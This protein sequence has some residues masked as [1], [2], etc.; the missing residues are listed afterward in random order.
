MG[1][2]NRRGIECVYKAKM[3]PQKVLIAVISLVIISSP[4]IIGI[5]SDCRMRK[6][7]LNDLI[8]KVSNHPRLTKAVI[9]VESSGNRYAKSPKGAIGL[10]QIRPSVWGPTLKQ[11]GIIKRDKDL[12]DPEMNIRA[13]EY[14]LAHYRDLTDGDL[15]R[16][17]WLYNGKGDGYP[18]KVMA[19]L[20]KNRKLFERGL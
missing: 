12:Y 18:K 17:L 3:F 15:R 11:A 2:Q 19:N 5:G 14:I 13:G 1:Y 9:A 16:A 4:L 6:P 8:N 20:G 10:M 7:S